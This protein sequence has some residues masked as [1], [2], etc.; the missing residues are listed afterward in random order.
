MTKAGHVFL[1]VIVILISL[2]LVFNC[3]KEKIII[4]M[5]LT[6]NISLI[7]PP[8]GDLVFSTMPV[9]SWHP[10]D[11]A[12]GYQVQVATDDVF[13]GP[14]IDTTISDTSLIVNN[15]Y[16]NSRYYWRVRAESRNQIRGDWSDAAIRSFL[17][18]NNTD[19]IRLVAVV[20]TPGTPQDVLV[21]DDIA[22]I[23]DGHKLL[24]LVDVGDPEQPELIGN[25]DREDADFAQAVW[26]LP[27][28]DIAYIADSDGRLIALDTSRPLNPYSER[29]RQVGLSQNLN[30]VTGILYRDTIYA[31]TVDGG[32]GHR[33]LI[34]Y[35]IIY[36]DGRPQT[37][38]EYM[39]SP[40]EL[41]DD[42]MGVCFDSFTVTVEYK[43]GD[44]L[45]YENQTGMFILVAADENGL[46]WCDVS[47]NHTFTGEEMPPLRFPRMLGWGDTP[48][49]AQAVVT[50]DRIA[51]VADDRGGLMIF[52]LP[53]TIPAIDH[54]SLYDANPKLIGD[55]NTSGRTK[56]LCLAGNYC[57]LA[58][59]AAGLK[60]IDISNP[61]APIFIAA[62][63][64]EYAYGVWADEN[65][66]YLTDRDYGLMIFR[67]EMN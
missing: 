25:I 19:F 30:D 57:F 31:F 50:R 5:P 39:V 42:G 28:D 53:D 63:D 22:Y 4:Y 34:F 20:Q 32:Y 24:T 7:A 35:Q 26:K 27:G 36:A 18:D 33:R 49:W 6:E 64:T 46:G 13:R 29:S 41:F 40:L 60:V 37:V 51:Y 61:K 16:D 8:D 23:A 2:L 58:D 65:F 9:M 14:V 11:N 17:L 66:I 1:I 56:D 10:I 59:G 62:Y 52:S 43:Q 48:S 47:A 12:I 21:S 67:N 55:I 44:S 45:Y 38:P 15:E 54:D 3:A